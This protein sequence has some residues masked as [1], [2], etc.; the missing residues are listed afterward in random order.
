M[1]GRKLDIMCYVTASLGVVLALF[2]VLHIGQPDGLLWTTVFAGG[3]IL[4]FLTLKRDMPL[5]IARVLAVLSSL[6]MFWFFAGFFR[7][8]PHLNADWYERAAAIDAIGL[9][10]AGFA[11]ITILSEYSC[12]MKAEGHTRRRQQPAHRSDPHYLAHPSASPP[13]SSRFK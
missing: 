13:N 4:A 2:A 6:A 8:A 12:R 9:L 1:A 5:M 11:M 10:F 7:L 3:A